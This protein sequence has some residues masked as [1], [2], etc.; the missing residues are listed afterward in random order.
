MD[1]LRK[2]KYG[3][4]QVTWPDGSKFDS[5]K[6]ANRYFELRLLERA[7]RITKLR[8]QVKFVLIPA[9]KDKRGKILEHECSYIADFV[10]FDCPMGREVVEDCKGYK[11]D[12]YKIKKKMMLYFHGIPIMET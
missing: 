11:T 3:A 2:N 10:Y 9:Q 6:E 5:Q 1:Y 7:G 4:K 12:V 8:R